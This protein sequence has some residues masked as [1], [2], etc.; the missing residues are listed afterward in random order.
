MRI[1]DCCLL[2]FQKKL[3]S[4]SIDPERLCIKPSWIEA[5]KVIENIPIWNSVIHFHFS[6]WYCALVTCNLHI[7]SP[8]CKP[9]NIDYSGLDL[10]SSILC[11]GVLVIITF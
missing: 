6:S 11:F 7:V 4:V 2:L 5:Q 3:D 10:R 1:T 9:I 8:F